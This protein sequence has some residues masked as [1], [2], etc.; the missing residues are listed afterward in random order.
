MDQSEVDALSAGYRY[1]RDPP[2]VDMGGNLKQ[3]HQLPPKMT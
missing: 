1:M 3:L 2:T